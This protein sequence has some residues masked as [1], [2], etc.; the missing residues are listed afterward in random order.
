MNAAETKVGHQ[1]GVFNFVTLPYDDAQV[2]MRAL[3]DLKRRS[4]DLPEFLIL[5]EHEPVFTLG[6]RGTL[7]D[8][9]VPVEEI[10]RRGACIKQVERGGLITYHGPGQLV[11]YPVFSL[12]A[13]GLGIRDLVQ[14][15]E[16]SILATLAEFGIEANRKESYPGV[17]LG[18][19]VKIASLGLAVRG[20]ITF[21]GAALNYGSTLTWF[22]LIRPCGL[23]GVRMT[24]MCQILGESVDPLLLRRRLLTHLSAHFRLNLV[25]WASSLP[26]G[27]LPGQWPESVL[28]AQT[29]S[30]P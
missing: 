11:V 27:S 14:K 13:L 1:C 30:L 4:A 29:L 21:H 9:L 28:S 3:V 22:D 12:R 5:T 20:G 17:W 24:S 26:A 7:S 10:E 19:D 6:R 15:L 2:M 8:V 25:D 16:A 23:S 18:Q